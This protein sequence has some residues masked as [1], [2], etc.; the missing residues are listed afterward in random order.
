[1]GNFKC[2]FFYKFYYVRLHFVWSIRCLMDIIN[3]VKLKKTV[4]DLQIKL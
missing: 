2:E 1:M 3:I 4:K